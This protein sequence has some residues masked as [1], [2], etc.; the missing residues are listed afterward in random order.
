MQHRG[1]GQYR[2]PEVLKPLKSEVAKPKGKG[3][4][5]TVGTGTRHAH[6]GRTPL[7]Q[8]A[9][10]FDSAGMQMAALNVVQLVFRD[11]RF[12]WGMVGIQMALC[13]ADRA[14]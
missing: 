12:A 4:G 13:S 1:T 11:D 10:E 6:A 8:V 9:Y 7:Q 3:R 2:G 5:G 14:G